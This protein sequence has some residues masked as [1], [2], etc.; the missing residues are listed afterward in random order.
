M[1]NKAI[2]KKREIDKERNQLKSNKNQ[3]IEKH[4][5]NFNYNQ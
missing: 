4:S 5:I 2:N 1:N 3:W